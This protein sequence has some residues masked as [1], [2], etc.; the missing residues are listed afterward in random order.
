MQ[1]LHHL[2]MLQ[3][4]HN[5]RFLFRRTL[6]H[7]SIFLL[8][9]IIVLPHIQPALPLDLRDIQGRYLQPELLQHVRLNLLISRA[10]LKARHIHIFQ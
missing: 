4:L 3:R 1:W 6:R 10:L 5:R 9:Q 7:F 2:K 8:R